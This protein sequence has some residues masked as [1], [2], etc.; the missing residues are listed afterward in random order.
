ME[1]ISATESL[2]LGV[3]EVI[4]LVG[5]HL[6]ENLCECHPEA[7]SASRG[8]WPAVPIG[9]E[10]DCSLKPDSSS[11]TAPFGMTLILESPKARNPAGDGG[12][13]GRVEA[14]V[15]VFRRGAVQ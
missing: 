3:S 2:Q 11:R 4:R 6:G 9:I 13:R 7:S 10:C 12:L 5:C 8:I 1:E 15:F 14:V